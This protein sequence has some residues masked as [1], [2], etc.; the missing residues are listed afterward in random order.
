MS[1]RRVVS[2]DPYTVEKDGKQGRKMGADGRTGGVAYE[3]PAQAATALFEARPDLEGAPVGSFRYS[4]RGFA[5]ANLSESL[6]DLV[7]RMCEGLERPRITY[8]FEEL[9]T[10]RFFGHG[11]FHCDGHGSRDEVHRLLTIGGAPTEGEDGTWLREGVVWEYRGDFLHR[12][13]P[14]PETTFRLMLRVSQTSMRFRDYW[15]VP[16]GRRTAQDLEYRVPPQ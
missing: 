6:R 10:G 11:R 15:S 14:A 13:S 16:R 4:S 12:A 2:E 7:A 1:D 5:D 3:G 9:S 8:R